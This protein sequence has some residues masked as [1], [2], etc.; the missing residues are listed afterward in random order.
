MGGGHSGDC[1]NHFLIEGGDVRNQRKGGKTGEAPVPIYYK[2][3]MDLLNGI[4]EGKWA[5]GEA[6]PPERRIAEEFGVSLGTVNRAI[7]N[8]VGE[9]YLYRIQGKGTFVS[10]TSIPVENVR[11][12]RLRT[13]FKSADPTFKIKLVDMAVISGRLPINGFLRIRKDQELYRLK[14]IFSSGGKPLTYNISY[15]PQ[16]MFEGLD[17]LSLAHLEKITLYETVEKKY[18]LPTVFNQEMFR[19]AL[20]DEETAGVLGIEAGR[21]VL[22]IDMLSFT[23]RDKPYEY[24]VTYCLA[25]KKGMFR[26]M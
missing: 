4:E 7:M 3:Q 2:L 12:T 6:I 21:P 10:G 15:L 19:V 24:R 9:G 14:R 8:L 13:D 22:K 25:D 18:G 17:R 16:K 20:A 23:Y 1:A 26:E 11:Y 5:P